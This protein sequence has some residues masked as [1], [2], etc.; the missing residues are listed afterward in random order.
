MIGNFSFHVDDGIEVGEFFVLS[1]GSETSYFQ[2]IGTSLST[3]Y[4]LALLF[5][6]LLVLSVPSNI[7]IVATVIKSDL[8]NKPVNLLILV[9][10]FVNSVHR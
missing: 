3:R 5:L 1:Q 10:Q 8:N 6:T 4:W 9:D 2:S 7:A